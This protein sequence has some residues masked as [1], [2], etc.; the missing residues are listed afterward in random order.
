VYAGGAVEPV[1]NVPTGG[2]CCCSIA[3]LKFCN[4][5]SGVAVRGSQTGT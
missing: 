5:L 1:L 3:M 2:I 4:F